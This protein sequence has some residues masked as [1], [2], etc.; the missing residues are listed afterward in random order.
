MVDVGHP[1]LEPVVALGAAVNR[2]EDRSA[3]QQG[4]DKPDQTRLVRVR[5]EVVYGNREVEEIVTRF[6]TDDS[7]NHRADLRVDWA[8]VLPKVRCTA[9][10]RRKYVW[11]YASGCIDRDVLGIVA[12]TIR[13]RMGLRRAVAHPYEGVD[14]GMSSSLG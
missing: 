5:N 4:Y 1:E 10:R 2:G 14:I 13:L 11:D 9:A 12:F 8:R 3:V 7:D 6:V